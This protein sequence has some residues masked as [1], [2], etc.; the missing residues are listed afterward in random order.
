MSKTGGLKFFIAVILS[1]VF[2]HDLKGRNQR[3][4][5]VKL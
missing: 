3:S 5:P 1:S 2:E 4:I